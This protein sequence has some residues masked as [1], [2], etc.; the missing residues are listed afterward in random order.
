LDRGRIHWVTE[1]R[2]TCNSERFLQQWR[3]A[4]SSSISTNGARS[5][6]VALVPSGRRIGGLTARV[7]N[8]RTVS[9]GRVTARALRALSARHTPYD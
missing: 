2:I 3:C 4:V 8:A 6:R 1:D 5:I 7:R 9:W